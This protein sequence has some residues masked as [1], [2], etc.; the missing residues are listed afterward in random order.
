MVPTV[1]HSWGQNLL[2]CCST[3][4]LLAPLMIQLFQLFTSSSRAMA[5]MIKS[6][7]LLSLYRGLVP[8][9]TQIVPFA[10]LQFGSRSAFEAIWLSHGF[11]EGKAMLKRTTLQSVGCDLELQSGQTKD[12][13]IKSASTV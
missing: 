12:E 11:K 13:L 7:G 4:V 10:A 9:L 6:E 2:Y 5:L 1:R 3:F 8:T